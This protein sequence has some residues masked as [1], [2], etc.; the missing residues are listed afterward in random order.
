M[1]YTTFDNTH[2]KLHKFKVF[3]EIERHL[4][5][6]QQ[7]NLE[8]G[9]VQGRLSGLKSEES[10]HVRRIFRF[11]VAKVNDEQVREHCQNIFPRHVLSMYE[12]SA[13][14]YLRKS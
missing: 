4:A 8:H 1:F 2:R 9:A 14:K 7:K 12:C 11:L 13:V 5:A 3:L 6:H 10:G